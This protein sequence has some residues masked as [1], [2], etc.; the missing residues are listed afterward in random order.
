LGGEEGEGRTLRRVGRLGKDEA[1]CEACRRSCKSD[2]SRDGSTVSGRLG[3]I[4][5]QV[6]VGYVQHDLERF[7][8]LPPVH[9][10]Y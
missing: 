3:R 2:S 10:R 4:D 9:L 7:F 6:M 1:G 8:L 5:S